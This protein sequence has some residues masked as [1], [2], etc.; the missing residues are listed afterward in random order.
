MKPYRSQPYM[1]LV[2]EKRYQAN[3]HTDSMAWGKV[4]WWS[5]SLLLCCG[6]WYGVAVLI[7]SLT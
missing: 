3:T 4:A 5:A 6:I 7:M 2:V 1:A